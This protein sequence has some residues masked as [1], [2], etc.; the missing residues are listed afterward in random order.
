M[1]LEGPGCG[2]P[3]AGAQAKIKVDQDRPGQSDDGGSVINAA[4]EKAKHEQ[5][6][7]TATKDGGD[8]PTEVVHTFL[9]DG[10]EEDGTADHGG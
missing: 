7:Q 8:D 4:G 1:N 5:A 3:A 9:F 6:E 2:Q 10:T